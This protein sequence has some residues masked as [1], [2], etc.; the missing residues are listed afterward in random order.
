MPYTIHI[1]P[2]DVSLVFCGIA[3]S[4]KNAAKAT[5]EGARILIMAMFVGCEVQEYQVARLDLCLPSSGR[6]IGW[7]HIDVNAFRNGP[8]CV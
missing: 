3:S 5:I 1:G 4:R 6:S 2:A 8:E 7:E